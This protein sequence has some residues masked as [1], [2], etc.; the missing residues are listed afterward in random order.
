MK[1][2]LRQAAFTMATLALTVSVA[3]AAPAL[4]NFVPLAKSAGPAVVNISTER[5]VST[6]MGGGFPGMPP[7]MERFFEEFGPFWGQPQGPR[8]Q[9]SLG[10]GFIISSD[11]Y[12]V[13]NNH[14]VEGAD[15]VFVNLEGDSDRA[16][17]LEATVVGTDAE[18][19]IALLKVDAKRDLPVLNFGNSDTAE[20]GEWVVAIGN[21]FG[22]SNSVTAGILSA[23]GRD[24]HAGP[25]DNFLQTDASINP[26]NSGGP[27]INMA[28]EVIGINTAIVASGQGIG[29]AIPSNL[30]SRI[31]EELKSGKK[32]SRGWLGVTIQDVDENA[33]KALGLKDA[34]G[35]LIGSVLPDEPAA[36]AG[37]KAGDI[38]VR[39]GRDDI[40]NSTELLRSV[41]DLKPGTDVKITVLRNGKEFS[42]TVKLGE[43]ASQGM[44]Q[45]GAQ[46]E[47]GTSLGL[48]IRPLNKEDARSLQLPAN[49]EGLVIL[50]VQPGSPAQ[51]AGLR[52]GDVIQSANLTP[53]VSVD[54]LASIVRKDGRERGAVMLQV[55]RRGESFFVTVPLDNK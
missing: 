24:I 26:G 10:S 47:G 4:P 46:E 48:T 22:L 8:K 53:V 39:V 18:T 41:A 21:P 54:E 36:K 11:G 55:N 16:H 49:T 31:V 20:V 28:G 32:I 25:F 14:V 44:S 17:S 3:A 43:R 42:T 40:R 19:D 23:K 51:E 12:I 52:P 29:F 33:A 1:R 37:L 45:G 30:A 50:S 35:A 5:E 7:G 34:Q 9:S 27:L 2:T 6:R 15:K 13:T 38:I